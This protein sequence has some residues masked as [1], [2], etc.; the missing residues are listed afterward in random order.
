MQQLAETLSGYE[1]TEIRELE[2]KNVMGEKHIEFYP[3]ETSVTKT[4]VDL[5]YEPKN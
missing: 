1:F 4:V 3:N 2:G 5:F